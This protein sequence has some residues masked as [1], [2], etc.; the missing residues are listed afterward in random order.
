MENTEKNG[1][2]DTAK[3]LG[4]LL[5]GAAIGAGLGILFSKGDGEKIREKIKDQFNDLVDGVK[6]KVGGTHHCPGCNCQH[7]EHAEKQA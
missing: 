6:D 2:H 4:A 3:V 1:S 5:V 7:E